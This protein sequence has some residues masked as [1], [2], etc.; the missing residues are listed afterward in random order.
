MTILA[1]FM[2]SNHRLQVLVDLGDVRLG[3]HHGAER[4]DVDVPRFVQV[5]CLEADPVDKVLHRRR[6]H[7]KTTSVAPVKLLFYLLHEKHEVVSIIA[8]TT[9]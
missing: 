1:G 4:L 9:F 5:A 3:P 7:R 6:R 8:A 2:S